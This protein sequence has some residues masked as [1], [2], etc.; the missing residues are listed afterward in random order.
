MKSISFDESSKNFSCLEKG[1]IWDCEH[2]TTVKILKIAGVV[3]GVG[4]SAL[5][6]PYIAPLGLRSFVAS[7]AITGGLVVLGSSVFSFASNSSFAAS[8]QNQDHNALIFQGVDSSVLEKLVSSIFI[9]IL[10]IK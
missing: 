5:F 8:L 4:L 7:L 2:P 1:G 3:L 6:L 9:Y 10:S